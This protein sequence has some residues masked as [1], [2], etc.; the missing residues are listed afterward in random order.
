MNSTVPTVLYIFT[1]EVKSNPSSLGIIL[2]VELVP[3]SMDHPVIE[4][5]FPL[6]RREIRRPR[7]TTYC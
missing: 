4:A 6:K 1:K 5:V 3:A 7:V 2:C